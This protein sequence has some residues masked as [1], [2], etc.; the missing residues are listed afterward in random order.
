[1]NILDGGSD[2][3]KL[4][5]WGF[6]QVGGA[7]YTQALSTLPMMGQFPDTHSSDFGDVR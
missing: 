3:E 5:S 2:E 7:V 4:L 1:M 6:K